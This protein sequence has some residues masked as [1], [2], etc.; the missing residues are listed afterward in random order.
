M[1]KQNDG[2]NVEIL[3]LQDDFA[4]GQIKIRNLYV[5][6]AISNN[7][8]GPIPQP[9]SVFTFYHLIHQQNTGAYWRIVPHSDPQPTY[10]WD[11]R[12][13]VKAAQTVRQKTQQ[14]SAS[15]LGRK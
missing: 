3:L 8:P 2:L 12:R 5:P 10:D 9:Q 11:D 15:N 14:N 13:T 6:N 1:I 7:A 4:V